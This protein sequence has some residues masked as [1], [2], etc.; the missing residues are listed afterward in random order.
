MTTDDEVTRPDIASVQ[1]RATLPHVLVVHDAAYPL[2]AVCD[3][4]RREYVVR[5]LD[6]ATDA[7]EALIE[8]VY[9][10]V[11]CR[12]GGNVEAS[13]FHRLVMGSS[14][15]DLPMVFIVA[16]DATKE[17][18]AYVQAECAHWLS[19]HASPNDVLALVRRLRG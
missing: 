9:A 16:D 17:D 5:E 10:C 3:A 13:T 8:R 19:Q 11:V 2:D 7:I 1:R 15:R 6:A 14:F 18:V 12:V 4:L